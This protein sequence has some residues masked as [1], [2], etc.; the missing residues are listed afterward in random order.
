[1]G[2]P[3][4]TGRRWTRDRAS[5]LAFLSHERAGALPPAPDTPAQHAQTGKNKEGVD[6][7]P[8]STPS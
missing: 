2:V 4:S 7:I 5:G 6:L 3:G 8:R 1:L